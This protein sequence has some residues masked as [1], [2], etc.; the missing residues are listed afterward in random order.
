MSRV[1]IIRL[2]ALD[3]ALL[4]LDLWWGGISR[5]ERWLVGT[6]A[7]L[8]VV[9]ILIFGIIRPIQ[10]ARADA[11]ADI[12]TSET[13][14]ARVIAAGVLAPASAR[15]AMR[16][17]APIDMADASA[18]ATGITATFNPI[19]DGLT[20][21]IADAPYQ[22]VIGWIADIERTTPLRVR[23]LTMSPGGATGRVRASVELAQ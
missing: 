7:T 16:G 9:L 1:R 17:G 22:A 11:I 23:R 14:T 2:P 18:Q 21:E 15:P 19:A 13:L 20:A 8:I 10:A 6:L 5:R 4:K 12:R 3:A